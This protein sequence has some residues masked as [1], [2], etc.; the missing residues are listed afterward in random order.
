MEKIQKINFTK[1]KIAAIEPPD[2]GQQ[3]VRY[4]DTQTRGLF[5]LVT[6]AGTKTFYV[7]RKI[8]GKSELY[9]LGR[10]PEL[11]VEQARAKAGGFHAAITD[12]KDLVQARRTERA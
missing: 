7:R 12:G 8:K 1:K 2:D 3:Q 4:Y 11:T 5:L 6:A 10:F 9:V